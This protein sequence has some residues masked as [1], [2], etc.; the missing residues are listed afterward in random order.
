MKWVFWISA[1]VIAYTYLGYAGWLLLRCRW[2][3][4]PVRS[5][6]YAPSI[7]IVMVVRNEADVIERK[8]RNL[9]DLSYPS[10]LCEIVVISD[11]SRDGTNEIVA[12]YA[13]NARFRFIVKPE[14]QGKAARLNE[15]IQAASGEIVVFTD[16]RQQIETDALRVLAADFAD[17]AV[18]CSSGE[19]ML[20][21]AVHGE[22]TN[23]MGLYWKIEKKIRELES[24]CGSVVGATGAFYAVRR[25]LLVPIPDGTLLDDVFIPMHVV[26]QGL[27]VVFNSK[28]RAWDLADQGL[29]REF[30]RKVR[31]LSGNYQLLQL[32]PWLLTRENPILFEFISHKLLRLAVPFA[33]ITAFVA[34]VFLRAPI[35][36]VALAGQLGLYALASISM[37]RIARGGLARVADAALTFVVLNTAAGVAFTKFVTGRKVA[38]GG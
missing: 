18:G 12:R 4:R 36:R 23:R 29:D 8:L 26:R 15:A 38:W 16:A 1:G 34:S 3:P 19:L 14:S 32:A 31:T 33:L 6:A 30:S 24:G 27:R 22:A 5:A 37:T 25:N 11:G 7:S 17:P 10:E 9:I 13:G 2:R 20:G 35:Y 28:A 21:D